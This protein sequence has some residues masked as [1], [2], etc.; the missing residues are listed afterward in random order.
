VPEG[1]L[2][3]IAAGTS[4]IC[5]RVKLTP[6]AKALLREGMAP[7]EFVAALTG[8]KLYFDAI[9]FLAHALP[10]RE[11]I[12]WGGLCMQH[13]LGSKLSPAEKAAATAA[14]QWMMQPTEENRVAAG[15]TIDEAGPASPASALATA[16]FHIGGNVAPP[17]VPIFKAPAPHASQQAVAR[18]V[19]VASI[20]GEPAK[21][22]PTQH[23]YV[24]LAMQVAEGRLIA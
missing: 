20:R 22:A 18:A 23:S 16:A 15:K 13:A 2:I 17:D 8:K 24:E 10:V 6:D 19:K 7:Q 14:I 9:D 4:E 12:W 11:G 21:I 1:P 5:A 3:K